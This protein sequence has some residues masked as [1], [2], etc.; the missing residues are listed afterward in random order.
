MV[1][2]QPPDSQSGF[3]ILPR[4]SLY[5]MYIVRAAVMA[6]LL[7]ISVAFCIVYSEDVFGEYG[8]AVRAAVAASCIALLVYSA[9]S[10]AVYCRRY[11]FR[12]DD[13][14]IEVR[15]GVVFHTRT[16]VPVERVHQVEVQRGPLDRMF[17]LASVTV[18]TA[19]GIF[20]MSCLAVA[21]AEDVARRLNDVIVG[22]LKSR[23]RCRRDTATI[24]SS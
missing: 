5:A 14:E 15:S 19:G 11:R 2:E 9:A 6:V 12:I 1:D 10:P 22:M 17:G 24:R 21:D 7:A 4:E 18:T 16:L 8:G 13:D 3:R 20:S 23:E